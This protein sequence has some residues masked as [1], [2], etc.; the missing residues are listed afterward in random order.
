MQAASE[1]Y[2]SVTGSALSVSVELQCFRYFQPSGYFLIFAVK[3]ACSVFSG[4]KYD[5]Q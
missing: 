5:D 2:L 4:K 3:L 1:Y